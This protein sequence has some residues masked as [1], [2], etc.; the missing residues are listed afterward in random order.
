L[1]KKVKTPK[2]EVIKLDI[3]CGEGKHRTWTSAFAELVLLNKF[4]NL[5]DYFWRMSEY[6]PSYLTMI[7]LV[8]K[9]GKLYGRDK[10]AYYIYKEQAADFSNDVGLIIWKLK[11]Y[12]WNNTEF[13]LE[14]LVGIYKN[15][16]RPT[17]N[18]NVVGN[19]EIIEPKIIP[20]ELDL[21]GDI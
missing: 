7:K 6:A 9:L 8:G 10:L 20:S 5:P 11:N 4:G 1:V 17:K 15:L 14:Q 2:K 12:K 18:E 16:Y 3:I 19:T 21:L 13:T